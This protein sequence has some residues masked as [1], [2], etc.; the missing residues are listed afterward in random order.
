[1]TGFATYDADAVRRHLD[2]AGCIA[3]V[4]RAMATFSRDNIAQ[5]L[6]QIVEVAPSK[7]FALMPGML[8]DGDGFGSK[9]ISV[10]AD[11][12]RPGR[13]AHRGVVVLFDRSTG[14][15][16]AIGDAGEITDIRTACASA[17]ATDALARADAR[18]LG[19]FGT[20]S[21]AAS[22][23]R[24]IPLVR[25]IDRVLVWGRDVARTQAFARQAAIDTGLDVRATDDPRAAAASDIICT[26]TGS[27]TPI[28][29]GEWVR[30]GTHV[31]IVGSS[32]AGP[33]EV[34]AALVVASRYIADSRRSALAAAAE[35]LDAK[36]A[37][38]IGDDHIV[39]EI[40]EVLNGSVVG[41]TED[42]VV[43]LYK[44][45]GHVVQDLAALAYLHDRASAA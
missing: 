4:R 32:H 22:H 13:S 10:F 2:Y 19:I 31:N 1:M 27:R 43:T 23:V 44:S 5:P 45:L 20:G 38:L 37:G 29:L 42:A 28:L 14:A 11:P 34:D 15:V 6:R 30:P 12:A 26:V 40:G 24:A 18:T 7:M 41:R 17:V 9:V 8:G 21:L 36:A 25:P 16:T 35:F 3:A 33:V 39:A